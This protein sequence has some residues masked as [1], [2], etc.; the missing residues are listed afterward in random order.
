M[1]NRSPSLSGHKAQTIKKAPDWLSGAFY[2]VRLVAV[3]A[4]ERHQEHQEI[5]KD[6]VDA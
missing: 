4:K 5:T 1:S 6:V 2:W 3:T